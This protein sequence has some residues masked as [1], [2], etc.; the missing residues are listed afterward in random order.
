MPTA[1]INGFDMY[2]ERHGDDGE[3]LVMVHG[4]TGDVGDW[5]WQ[6]DEFSRTPPRAR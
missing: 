1:R 3:P 4:Y 5:A 2:F 6:L